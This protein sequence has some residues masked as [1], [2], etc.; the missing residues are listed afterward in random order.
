MKHICLSAALLFGLS[1]PAFA[2]T[3]DGSA[4]DDILALAR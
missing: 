4:V 2:Q 1:A 3:I